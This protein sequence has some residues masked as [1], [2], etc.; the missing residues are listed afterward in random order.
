MGGLF[1]AQWGFLFSVTP[2]KWGGGVLGEPPEQHMGEEEGDCSIWQ[3]ER[4]ARPDGTTD[5]AQH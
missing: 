3:A 2:L 1:L 5:I 4:K